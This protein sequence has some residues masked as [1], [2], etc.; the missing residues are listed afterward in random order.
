MPF[1]PLM[2]LGTSSHAGKTTLVA[3]LCRLFSNR[4]MKVAPFKAQNMSLNC[5]ATKNGEEIARSTAVQA[6]AAR[7]EPIVHMNPI[8][9]KPKNDL[10]SQVIFHGKEGGSPS[11]EAYFFSSEW[12]QKKL[13]V[14]KT[15]IAF[16][17]DKYDYIIAEGAGSF[18][19]PNF[20]LHDAVNMEI[21]HLLDADVYIVVDIDKG[22]VFADIIGS[23]RILELIAPDDIK[24]IKGILINKF[25]GSR[26]LLQPAIDFLFEQ[27]KLPVVGVIPY[28]ADLHLEEEDRV[29]VRF[30]DNAEI[31]IA[32]VYLPHL[33]NGSDFDPLSAEKNVRVRFVRSPDLLGAPD[34]IIL[35]GTKNPLWDLDYIRKIGWEKE[36]LFRLPNTPLMGICGGF[37]MMGKTLHDPFQVQSSLNAVDGFGLFDFS[38][39]FKREKKVSQVNYHPSM[40]NPFKQGGSVSGYE[41]H[42]GQ[43]RDLGT[44]DPLFYSEQGNEGAICLT[45]LYFGTFIHD[46]FK[47]PLFTRE[48]I[49]YLRVKKGLSPLTDALI[50]PHH[51]FNKQ[52]DRLADLLKKCKIYTSE[53]KNWVLGRAKAPAVES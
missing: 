45:P 18:A 33:A 52:C 21:A 9:L 11:A 38:I 1:K 53:L 22:G 42:C 4:G 50:D 3:G 34:L 2:I 15:S 32:V 8:L 20:R 36:L 16:L 17:R 37:E 23:L 29:K 51:E 46:I 5:Y 30:C 14:I 25:R 24:R 27:T 10:E 31:D 48:M 43:L 35:P 12:H 13:H 41:I 40:A 47:N 49:N 6:F 19:E 39:E 44:F 26:A 7:Q 28:L